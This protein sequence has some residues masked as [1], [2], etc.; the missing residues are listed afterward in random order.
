[1]PGGHVVAPAMGAAGD[2]AAVERTCSQRLSLMEAGILRRVDGPLD[3]EQCYVLAR[4]RDDCAFSR[5]KLVEAR[6][7]N[8]FSHVG[9]PLGPS[10]FRQL[11]AL[12]DTFT[13]PELCSPAFSP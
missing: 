11:S 13:R 6:H 8:K 9:T 10:F 3:I 2:D 1:M 4:Y 7:L 5:R 12:N